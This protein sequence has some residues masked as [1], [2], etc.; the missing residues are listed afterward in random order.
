MAGQPTLLIVS[1]PWM[2]FT[3]FITDKLD[4]EQ[5]LSLCS[6]YWRVLSC[7]V[8]VIMVVYVQEVLTHFFIVTY[9]IKW[10]TTSWTYSI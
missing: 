10:V 7:Y 8:N 4:R 6:A 5:C 9:Y 2:H 1:S 3:I